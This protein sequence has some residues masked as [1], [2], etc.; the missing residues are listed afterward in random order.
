MN[1]GE[2]YSVI[3]RSLDRAGNF[4][5]SYAT[6]TITFDTAPPLTG[7]TSPANASYIATLP[8][9]SGTL[10]D[11][12][13]S[14]PGVVQKVGVRVTQ[15]SDNSCWDGGGWQPS[16]VCPITFSGAL[17]PGAVS[18]WQSSW[19]VKAGN[20]PGGNTPTLNSGTSYYITTVSTDDAQPTGNVE[21]WYS[22]RGS[23]FTFDNTPPASGIATP[24][25]GSLSSAAVVAVQGGSWDNVGVSTIALNVQDVQPGVGTC[26]M[27]ALGFGQPCA[28]SWFKAQGSPAAWS[29]ASSWPEVT[30]ECRI[31]PRPC[32]RPWPRLPCHQ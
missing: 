20:P 18:V 26:Y 28:A 24:L 8:T 29:P 12:P 19:V 14:N 23:T 2:T 25:D 15:L 32:P 27:P 5:T 21:A 4:S 30:T 11:Q 10:A 22:P 1:S 31:R 13:F 6:Y 7:V 9:L 16:A 17:G 3:A